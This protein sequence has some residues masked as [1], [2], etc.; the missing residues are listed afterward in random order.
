ML[1]RDTPGVLQNPRLMKGVR[2]M[3]FTQSHPENTALLLTQN[4]RRVMEGE[5]S[6]IRSSSECQ[7]SGGYA[8]ADHDQVDAGGRRIGE[9]RVTE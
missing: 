6:M 5:F 2:D 1:R 3:R 8:T 9:D 4:L 7:Y